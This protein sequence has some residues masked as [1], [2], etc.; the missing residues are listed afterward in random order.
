MRLLTMLQQCQ[1]RRSLP[2][3]IVVNAIAKL[4]CFI[5]FF[6]ITSVF[7]HLEPMESVA[8]QHRNV[9]L[10]IHAKIKVSAKILVLVSIALAQRNIRESAANMNIV[11]VRM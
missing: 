1:M 10:V 9:A 5:T 2:G 11:P 6:R 7:V 8:K 3:M 4:T